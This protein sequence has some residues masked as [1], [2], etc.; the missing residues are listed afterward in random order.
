MLLTL[1]PLAGWAQAVNLSTVNAVKAIYQQGGDIVYNAQDRSGIAWTIQYQAVENGEWTTID[2]GEVALSFFDEDGHDVTTGFKNAGN[3]T[4]GISGASVNYSGSVPEAKRPA[5]TIQK[6][7]LIITID[8][9]EKTYG[10]ADPATATWA[11]KAGQSLP[12]PAENIYVTFGYVR[13]HSND[14]STE[15]VNTTTGYPINSIATAMNYN[16]SVD[17]TPVLKINPRVLTVHYGGN[18]PF[19]DFAKV[20][21][22]ENSEVL[23]DAVMTATTYKNWASGTVNGY[24]FEDEANKATLLT[25]NISPV[26]GE[27]NA[28]A[29][30]N[31]DLLDGTASH[32][33]PITF[34][35][36]TLAAGSNYTIEYAPRYMR[37]KQIDINT[38]DFFFKQVAG[39]TA[40]PEGKY[41][42]NGEE[43]TPVFEVYKGGSTEATATDANKLTRDHDFTV[44]I[45][46]TSKDAGNYTVKVNG[47]GNYGGTN[48]AVAAF[49]FTIEQKPLN[50]IALNETKVYNG[51]APSAPTGG[52]R[53]SYSGFIGE[54]NE[55]MSGFTK[56]TAALATGAS[57]NVGAYDIV[58]TGNNTNTNYKMIGY[59][60][61]G[62]FTVTPLLGVRIKATDKSKTYGTA[63]NTGTGAFSLEVDGTGTAPANAADRTALTSLANIA[64]TRDLTVKVDGSTEKV[65]SYANSLVPAWTTAGEALDLYKNYG[66]DLETPG[67]T[68]VK[69]DFEITPATVTII[70]IGDTKVYGTADDYVAG[71]QADATKI[72]ISGTE[73]PIEN[74]IKTY[75]TLVREAGEDV[76]FYN[77]TVKDGTLELTE[78]YSLDKVT[79]SNGRLKITPA[80]LTVT[81]IEQTVPVMATGT[82]ALN[83]SAVKMTGLINNAVVQD[84]VSDIAY[85]LSY[86]GGVGFTAENTYDE[87]IVSA[88]KS[89]LPDGAKNKN[90]TITWN[91]GK[92][93]VTAGAADLFLNADDADVAAK[94]DA[95]DGQTANIKIKLNRGN[96]EL[97]GWTDAW[98]AGEWNALVLPFEISVADLS[99]ALGYAIVNVVD[100][101]KTTVAEKSS[102][103]K[104]A[105]I[106]LKLEMGLNDTKI[107][108]NNPIFVKTSSAIA[109][110]RVIEFGT[111][112]IV[113]PA[114]GGP[115]IDADKDNLGIKFAGTYEKMTLDKN[116]SYI[117]FLADNG[118]QKKMQIITSDNSEF[119]IVPYNAFIVTPQN[120]LLAIE[121]N[122]EELDGSTTTI[123]NIDAEKMAGVAAE[124]WY[125]LNGVKLQG[126]PTEKGIYI[127]NGK[128]IVIK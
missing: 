103:V 46:A 48:V 15:Q 118:T 76:G 29:K 28:N 116:Y 121:L 9:I 6:A 87:G 99:K 26:M 38:T 107:P 4:I 104:F 63:D 97:S 58:V 17:G 89:P 47:M 56:A 23:T 117:Q 72:A 69:G 126:V 74:V 39:A 94:I 44:T 32:G 95:N 53:L 88:A 109:A 8:N 128:K 42:Y 77:I 37:I 65:G 101:S 40:T 113:K 1:L 35:T 43:Q 3:Y 34:N 36:S 119:D 75:P 55:D 64:V 52:F 60:T 11:V 106:S 59:T 13:T 2:E 81:P 22:Q 21:G 83:Q 16:I 122:F 90:Y 108:A 110:D 124:G 114:T 112:T 30:S 67:V 115:S 86:A 70:T 24:T 14:G 78:N 33:Y 45:S 120:S 73:D 62:K 31:G 57:A 49:N 5:F 54:D 123:R 18:E 91:K 98:R 79:Y 100:P 12:E 111:Q 68:L 93:I 61:N 105:K 20:Y 127:N 66:A 96:S 125:T 25:G 71:V 85:E 102:G 7:P 82:P 19:D 84:A 51:D 27:V 41:V 10:D 80:E 92:L 50:V